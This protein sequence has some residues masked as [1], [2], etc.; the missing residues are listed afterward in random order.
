MKLLITIKAS[1]SK[2]SEDI[3]PTTGGIYTITIDGKSYYNKTSNL[4]KSIN[5]DLLNLNRGTHVNEL[6]QQLYLPTKELTVYFEESN[7]KGKKL[8]KELSVRLREQSDDYNLLNYKDSGGNPLAL[9]KGHP[10]YIPAIRLKLTKKAYAITEREIREIAEA[11]KVD[12]EKMIEEYLAKGNTLKSEE[13][14]SLEVLLTPEAQA[15][16][17]GELK[18]NPTGLYRIIVGD[19]FYIG[20][21]VSLKDRIEKHINLLY[22]GKHYSTRLQNEFNKL[23]KP[24]A[25]FSW[26]VYPGLTNKELFELENQAIINELDNTG[27]TNIKDPYHQPLPFNEDHP[28]YPH[29]LVMITNLNGKLNTLREKEILASF[30]NITLDELETRLLEQARVVTERAAKR[31]RQACIVSGN[32][33]TSVKE[34]AAA[35][36]LSEDTVR[37]RIS[38]SGFDDHYLDNTR[39]DK[40]RTSAPSKSITYQGV[41]YISI[42]EASRETGHS[43]QRIRD[44]LK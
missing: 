13:K 33:Y 40:L 27:L 16:L 38:A 23:S 44:S 9:D 32:Q 28:S 30:W 20:S 3:L 34:A 37:Y 7:S 21:S 4:T 26:I 19:L 43:R 10:G 31:N 2:I 24:E 12:P 17:K 14:S 11:D 18:D 36:G 8:D 6:L 22:R 42:S 29:V 25:D 5:K 15:A 39:R 1:T 35:L 41:E